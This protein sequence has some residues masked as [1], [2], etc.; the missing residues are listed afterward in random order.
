MESLYPISQPLRKLDDLIFGDPLILNNIASGSDEKH[1]GREMNI[2]GSGGA[3][4]SYFV[5]VRA[6]PSCTNEIAERS[7]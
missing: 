1:V 2:W 5:C 4:S 7:L 3:H 6:T